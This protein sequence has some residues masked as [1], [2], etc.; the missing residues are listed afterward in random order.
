MA[1]KKILIIISVIIIV[2]A[3]LGIK[4]YIDVMDDKKDAE[5]FF[6]AEAMDQELMDELSLI[7]Q[8]KDYFTPLCTIAQLALNAQNGIPV[9]VEDCETIKL[10]SLPY[11]AFFLEEVIVEKID[12][13]KKECEMSSLEYEEELNGMGVI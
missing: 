13:I 9:T 11:Y 8:E 5:I 10:K 2:L 12:E 6:S 1:V 3:S 7:C 4:V